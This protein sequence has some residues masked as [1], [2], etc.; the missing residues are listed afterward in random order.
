MVKI[1]A[2]AIDDK[3]KRN[4]TT[5]AKV[6]FVPLQGYPK[7]KKQCRNALGYVDIR[8]QCKQECGSWKR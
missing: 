6:L 2:S 4:A 5:L 3:R 8:L 7:T 1:A